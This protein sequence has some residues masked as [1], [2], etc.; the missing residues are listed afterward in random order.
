M[1]GA[2]EHILRFEEA[3]EAL[4]HYPD[5]SAE[6]SDL[7]L[8]GESD[9][10]SDELEDMKDEQDLVERRITRMT[11]ETLARLLAKQE[12]L[13]MGSD[14]LVLFDDDASVD[15][16]LADL[17]GR[18]G[19]S[20][21]STALKA[22]SKGKKPPKDGSASSAFLAEP[23]EGFDVMDWARP[24]L[25]KKPKGQKPSLPFDVSDSELEAAL[26]SS[27][28]GDRSKKKM[29]KQE[30]EELRA[31]GLLGVK[32]NEQAKLKAKY[33]EGM[34]L[35]EIK[36]EIKK[37]L[38]SSHG[39][40]P[41]PPMDKGD[42]KIVHEIANAFKLKSKSVGAGTSRSPILYKTARSGAYDESD[43]NAI[44]RQLRQRRFLPRKDRKAG[45]GGPASK[46][47]GG[48][49][50]S[51]AVSYRDGEVVGAAAPEL[52]AENRGRAMLEKMGWSTGTALG[53]LDNK[54]ILQ[55]VAHVVKISK[56]GLG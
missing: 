43:V 22:K 44:E 30:R 48:G 14:E 24:S 35:D 39:T 4:P 13:G 37:F 38:M 26:I 11:D 16:D 5:D 42:R 41:L 53:A 3:E 12:E 15:D 8:G 54:G 32:H 33:T 21:A 1:T 31:Q 25:I 23:Y 28:A 47:N 18:R 9:L 51:A 29:K 40:L 19:T 50:N 55:P 17:G 49:F 2:A 10:N 20:K 46:R 27:W 6:S 36:N 45:K 56:A 7:D 52:G 34:T